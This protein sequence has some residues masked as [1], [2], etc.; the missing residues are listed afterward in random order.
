MIVKSLI[1]DDNSFII[2]LLSD[3]IRQNHPNIALLGF[4]KSGKEGLEK[5]RLFKPDLVF[6]DVEMGDMTG[7]DMLNQLENI[8]FQTI[9]ITSHSHYAIKA[10]RFN[11]LDYLLKPI[12]DKEL[13]QA[14]KRHTSKST[15]QANQNKVHQ[16]LINLQTKKVEEQSLLLQTQQG[17][18]RLA[19]KHIVKIEGERNYSYIYLSD[20]T[21]EL[22]SKT[23]GYFEDI[24]ADKG[25]IRCHRSFLVN[26]FHIDSIQNQDS[27]LLKDS[28]RVPISRRKKSDAKKWFRNSNVLL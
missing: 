24:L 14:I 15:L 12:N 23:L 21:K 5:I 18:L 17:T 19:L 3:Q 13:A 6:L 11:A 7:F 27:F 2:D 20:N 9:F 26:R 8:I 25:F 16:A 1:I 22:S 10:I 4:A 28:S